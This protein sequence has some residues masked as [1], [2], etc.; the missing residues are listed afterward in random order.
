MTSDFFTA[1]TASFRRGVS[2]TALLMPATA[3]VLKPGLLVEKH[4]QLQPSSGQKESGPLEYALSLSE[5]AGRVADHVSL[6]FKAAGSPSSHRQ[7]HLSLLGVVVLVLIIVILA[8]MWGK[9]ST[10]L[11][12]SVARSRA[13]FRQSMTGQVP[14]GRLA[15]WFSASPKGHSPGGEAQASHSVPW[16]DARQAMQDPPEGRSDDLEEE[17]ASKTGK[18]VHFLSTPTFETPRGVL[19][20]KSPVAGGG[21]PPSAVGTLPE[22]CKP[23]L[24]DLQGNNAKL[25]QS[26]AATW[27]GA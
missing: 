24:R 6:S 12:G 22:S 11:F 16:R 26:G 14:G 20:S 23:T 25:L 7:L 9:S 18:A 21:E 19:V 4:N 8:Y 1:A 3:A 15:G 5:V 17:D 2:I 13:S 10:S 27:R